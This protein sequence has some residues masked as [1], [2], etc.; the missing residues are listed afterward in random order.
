M[1]TGFFKFLQAIIVPLEPNAFDDFENIL[2]VLA[3]I[4]EKLGFQI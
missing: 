2:A 3:T 1:I 4:S